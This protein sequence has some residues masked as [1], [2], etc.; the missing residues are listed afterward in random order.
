MQ[1]QHKDL[2]E[3][4]I[5]NLNSQGGMAEGMWEMCLGACTADLTTTQWEV[6]RTILLE[7]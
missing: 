2:E 7:V 3:M 4:I 6:P 5:L 1:G